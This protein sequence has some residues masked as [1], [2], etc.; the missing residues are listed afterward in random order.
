MSPGHRHCWGCDI[1]GQESSGLTLLV[2]KGLLEKLDPQWG[3]E[4]WRAWGLDREEEEEGKTS[5][6]GAQWDQSQGH[7]LFIH[8]SIQCLCSSPCGALDREVS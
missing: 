8:L 4:G 3:L 1:Q 6:E 5:L 7:S 2:E